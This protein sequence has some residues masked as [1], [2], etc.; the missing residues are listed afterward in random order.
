MNLYARQNCH[1]IIQSNAFEQQKKPNFFY[2]HLEFIELTWIVLLLLLFEYRTWM[3]HLRRFVNH[4]CTYFTPKYSFL[5]FLNGF[6]CE[7]DEFLEIVKIPS[8]F[9]SHFFKAQLFGKMDNYSESNHFFV[10]FWQKSSHFLSYFNQK[11]KYWS[12]FQ[13]SSKC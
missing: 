10:I 9:F 2:C 3:C 11:M 1:F 8:V 7:I 4:I 13:P 5:I 6:S 12:W